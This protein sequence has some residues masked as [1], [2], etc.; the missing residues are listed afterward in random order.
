M[1]RKRADKSN[2]G[3]PGLAGWMDGLVQKLCAELTLALESSDIDAI[4]D[5]RV[6]TRRLRAAAD[7]IET[8][9]GGDKDVCRFRRSLGR[10][11]R[12]LGPLRDLD[13][14]IGHLDERWTR[15]RHATAAQWVRERILAERVEQRQ[16]DKEQRPL[17][18]VLSQ[19]GIWWGIERHVR[20]I[21]P[22]IHQAVVPRIMDQLG[23]FADK[24]ESLSRPPREGGEPNSGLPSDPHELRIA[25][26]LLRYTL[27]IAAATGVEVPR[28]ILKGFKQM[29][30]ALGLWHDYAMLAQEILRNCLDAE[31]SFHNQTLCGQVI[32]LAEAAS[33][34]AGRQLA[35]FVSRWQ[36]EGQ[37]IRTGVGEVAASPLPES[38]PALPDSTHD[39]L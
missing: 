30:D 23:A 34:K 17:S 37:M 1:S 8:I 18:A 14:L 5:A 33:V 39:L 4:H 20:Q 36:Q 9:A 24:A 35:A 27:E 26:K 6:A 21:E 7:L 32:K 25:G 11:R 31:L 16:A 2:G 19:L 29:Q 15:R 13:V 10:I 12:R 28:P 22:Q 38:S 3:S